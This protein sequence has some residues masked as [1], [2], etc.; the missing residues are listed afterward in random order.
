MYKRINRIAKAA[1]TSETLKYA[2]THDLATLI[3]EA[4]L[5]V[6]NDQVMN[7]DSK[8]DAKAWIVKLV[9]DSTAVERETKNALSTFILSGYQTQ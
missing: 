9:K 6:D 5:S 3:S 1:R 7:A 4:K 8:R 2:G